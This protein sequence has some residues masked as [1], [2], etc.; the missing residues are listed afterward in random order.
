MA[1]I[2]TLLA[3]GSSGQRIDIAFVAEGYQV[4]ERGQFLADAARF[5]DYMLG[6]GNAKLNSPFSTYAHYF[7]ASALFVASQQSGTDQPNTGVYVNTYFNASQYGSDGRLMYGDSDRVAS[8]VA[9]ALP[10]D[11]HEMTVVLVNSQTYSGSGGPVVWASAG[12][13]Q[14][15]E[16][17]L[18][19]IGHSYA[20]L[21]DEYADSA[22]V[23]SYPLGTLD[24]V[25]LSTSATSVPWSAWLGYTDS[26]GT[27]A[28]YQGGYY[29]S[30]GVW[31]A[32]PDSKMFH[33]GVAF[34]A[35]EKE[36]FVLAYYKTIGD[37]LSLG[38]TVPGLY[39]AKTPDDSRLAFS[40]SVNGGAASSTDRA[41][42]DA[43]SL[44]VYGTDVRIGVTTVDNTGLVRS[45]LAQTQQSE[46]LTI[47]AVTPASS[48]ASSGA[49]LAGSDAYYQFDAGNNLIYG[50]G[51]TG[52]YIDGG[53][54]V[55]TLALNARSTD[56]SLQKLS[57]GTLV[58][59]AQDSAVFALR[60]IERV[61]FSDR[62]LAFDLDGAAGAT[63]K[64]LGAMFGTDY[65]RPAYVSAG[66]GLFDGGRSLVQVA[67]LVL[68]S[69]EF[70]QL[71]GGRSDAAVVQ[72][73]YTHVVGHAP[74]SS[75]FNL[76]TGLLRDGTYTQ[77]SLSAMA[78]E[79]SLNQGNVNLVGLS[80]TGVEFW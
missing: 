27:V 22:L 58:L 20:S 23:A 18:H 41:W 26:L 36:A 16:I 74:S 39:H 57:T 65:L 28:A 71:A 30:S 29:R 21:E 35:P 6:A 77:A 47:G 69:T 5:L 59:A 2:T 49:V 75:E 50:G 34:S 4:G 48:P 43:A 33:L 76:Y 32:T 64:V 55:D 24:S 51:A 52:C 72:A 60:H 13:L 46:T 14:S 53:G 61:Q 66:L 54:G 56:Y 80:A 31:R 10:G 42:F 7:N 37:Y 79:T 45:G 67:E 11:A 3:N 68:N 62:K 15:A 44:G 8:L 78:A 38:A 1:D 63:L 70:Q 12:N 73:L 40:W 17:L 25:H 9:Q 19:E